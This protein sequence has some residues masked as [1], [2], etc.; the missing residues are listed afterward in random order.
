METPEPHVAPLWALAD[1]ILNNTTPDVS[2][3]EPE[4]GIL[5]NE[6]WAYHG[7]DEYCPDIVGNDQDDDQHDDGEHNS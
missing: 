5:V 4:V 3:V 7:G 6:A 2:L 1:A